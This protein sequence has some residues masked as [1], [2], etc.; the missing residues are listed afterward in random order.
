MK[1]ERQHLGRRGE[2]EA[3]LHL[4]RLGHS[5][6]ERN[7]RS[8]HTELDIISLAQDGLHFVEVK[9][10]TAPCSADPEE[11]VGAAKRRS[12]VR[13]A[14]GWLHS[15]QRAPLREQEVFFDIISVVFDHNTTYINYYPQ[16]FIP[17]Y[18]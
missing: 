13:A 7:F 4:Q 3:C 15:P 10:R 1:T 17:I 5:I 6:L 9:S 16:A 2:D 18:V 11:N 12:L 8:G 14:Q